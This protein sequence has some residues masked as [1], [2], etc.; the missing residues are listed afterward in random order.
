MRVRV[1]FAGS[2][3]LAQ[4]IIAG[5]PADLFLSASEDWANEVTARGLAAE[6][7][8]LLRNTLVIVTPAASETEL[9]SPADLLRPAFER[10]AV[11]D[12]ESVPAGRYA[13]NALQAAGLWEQVRPRLV[14]G[15]NV[16]QALVF[17]E[18]GEAQAGLVYATDAAISRH[19]RVAYAFDARA[20]GPIVYPLVRL[21]GDGPAAAAARRLYAALRSA[22]A[23]AVFEAYGFGFVE[24]EN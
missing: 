10:I 23:R 6:R 9:A 12:T 22:E 3:T 17:V 18:R 8:D 7:C 5:A 16:R 13:R 20:T 24:S 2:S 21:R 19:V 14:Q 15:A 1:N 4:Q 11:A